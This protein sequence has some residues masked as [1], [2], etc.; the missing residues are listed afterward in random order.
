MVDTTVR[1][2]VN[3][4]VGVGVD[5]GGGICGG[6][7][8]GG[9]SVGDTSCS[10]CSGFLCEKFKKRYDD[11]IIYLQK[12]SELVNGFK[13]KRGV[14]VIPSNKVWDPYTPQRHLR[15]HEHYDFTEIIMD[16][17]FYTN[18]KKRYDSI[19]EEA[20]TAGGRS[21][22]HIIAIMNMNNTQFVTLEILLHEGR[23]NV[24]DCNLMS[25]EHDNFFT[26]IQHVFELLPNLLRQSGIMKYLP[27]KFLNEP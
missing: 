24:Y 9:Q 14:R 25:M 20:T 3:I 23:M 21:L 11:S 15:F 12:L 18:F 10:R 19:S 1:V 5:V 22:K 27:E 17:N 8:I 4:G 16:L 6:A 2:G 7:S 13:Y 26:F